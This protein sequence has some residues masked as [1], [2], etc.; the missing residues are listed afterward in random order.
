MRLAP[1]IALAIALA[2]CGGDD[3]EA[4]PRPKAAPVS[5]EQLS[6]DQVAHG[7]RVARLL[8]CIGCHGE[9]LTGEDWSEAVYG[10]LWTANLTQA[11]ARY[12]DAQLLAA[13]QGGVRPDGSALWGMPSH[14]FTQLAPADQGALIAFLR[15]QRPAGEVRP[16]PKFTDV[17]RREI[18]E[19]LFKSSLAEVR[20]QGK[21]WPPDAGRDHRVGRYIVRATCAECHGMDLAGAQPGPDATPRPDLRKAMATYD[22][23]AFAR[24]LR[25]GASV[26]GRHL[27]LMS[28]V[29]KSRYSR[30]TDGE[31]RAVGAYLRAL[32]ST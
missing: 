26:S 19:G 7:E 6:S 29:A 31:I 27:G 25:T 32:G 21:R 3:R 28:E 10:V 20:E 24:L 5:F 23:A 13:I 1:F 11:V 12:D 22:D 9:D 2:G 18:A 17:A 4:P 16:L 30:M 8:G 14:L 15:S